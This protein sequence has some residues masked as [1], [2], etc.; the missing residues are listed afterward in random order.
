MVQSKKLLIVV[1]I[2]AVSL[3]PRFLLVR[4]RA[5]M[6]KRPVKALPVRVGEWEAMEVFVCPE[7]SKEL[8]EAVWQRT[9]PKNP[10]ARRFYVERDLDDGA[11]PVHHIAVRRTR[12]VPVS[13]SVQKVLPAGTEFLE[14]WYRNGPADAPSS[15]LLAVTVVISGADKRSLHRPE[16]CM[17]GQGWQIALR[18]RLSLSLSG[19]AGK[20]L[21]VTRL[22]MRQVWL[23]P[24][25]E[26]RETEG[27]ALY[28]YMSSE[29][30]TG[31]NLKRLL[32]G[33]WDRVFRGVDYRWSYAILFSPAPKSVAETSRE[34]AEFA[35]QLF[36]LIYEREEKPQRRL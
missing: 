11:C 5:V 10:E 19:G 29:R 13:F 21:E 15:R 12:D 4:V 36:P 17:Q 8:R 31:R 16:R 24:Q 7:C 20:K 34:M 2:L 18:D 30:V 23:T 14:K 1:C 33:W 26:K 9:A 35:T 3:I 28:W 25:Q 32:W 27:V 22:V 6:E